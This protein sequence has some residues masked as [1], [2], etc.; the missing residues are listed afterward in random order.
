MERIDAA[1]ALIAALALA[2]TAWSKPLKVLPFWQL[3]IVCAVSYPV[4]AKL[5]SALGSGRAGAVWAEWTFLISVGLLSTVLTA[6]ALRWIRSFQGTRA[7]R[8]TYHQD[9]DV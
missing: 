1:V 8:H 6:S 3:I 2:V 7:D 5:F 4:G 9:F